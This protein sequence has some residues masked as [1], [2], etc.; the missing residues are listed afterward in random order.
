[1]TSR[2]FSKMAVL[3]AALTLTA[4]TLTQAQEKYPSRPVDIVVTFGPGGGADAMGRKMSLLLEKQLGVPFPVSNVGGASGN[5]GL[6]KVL[7]AA[8]DG[9]TVATLIALT[10][11]SWA[12]GLGSA[13]VEDFAI[14]AVTQDSPSLLFVPRDSPFK[15]FKD[16]LEFSK[17][18]PGKLK[19]ATSGYGTQDDITLKYFSARGYKLTNVPFAKPAERYASTV[20]MHTDAIYEEPG[21]VAPFLA[22]GQLRP[23]VVFDDER[24]PAFRSTPASKELGFEISD[25]PNFRTIAVSAKTPPDKIKK[26]ADA[27]NAALDT[28]EWKK[29]CSATYTCASHRYTPAQAQTYVKAFQDK[30]KGYLATFR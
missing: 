14:V 2:R 9:Y 21:D 27:V 5:A 8:P 1:M 20:G 12:S 7:T 25:L 22:A 24:H 18:N 13:K 10:V 4:T 23:L 19:V 30:V 16:L 28:P 11:S 29:F 6:T 3:A 15:T 17:S 26:L